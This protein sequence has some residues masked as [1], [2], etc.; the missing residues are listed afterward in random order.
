MLRTVTNSLVRLTFKP[1]NLSKC[2]PPP[3]K[4]LVENRPFSTCSVLFKFDPDAFMNED[5]TYGKIKKDSRSN[6]KNWE[7]T[8]ISETNWNEDELS[9]R[10]RNFDEIQLPKQKWDELLLP[11]IKKK[12][13]KETSEKSNKDFDVEKFRTENRI[14]IV[15]STCEVPDPIS[16]F[17]ELS[18]PEKL[19]D[20]LK[21]SG[22]ETPMPIQA[23][24]WPIVMSG[25]D[26]IGIG[27]TGSGKTLGFL[28][29]AFQHILEQENTNR[30]RGMKHELYYVLTV[31]ANE[32]F[33]YLPCALLV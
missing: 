3:S 31:M 33:N 9:S 7:D 32:Y 12:V 14:S 8:E 26:L 23:Q 19:K 13:S 1:L 29:P 30:L 25:S 28:L 15:Q 2:R 24:G 18:I 6:N 17:G 16:G 21:R 11:E 4:Y 22:F 20:R 27:E 10:N 5:E